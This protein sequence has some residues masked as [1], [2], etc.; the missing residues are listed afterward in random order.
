MSLNLKTGLLTFF[1]ALLKN[2]KSK[3]NEIQVQVL[4]RNEM[5]CM[6]PEKIPYRCVISINTPGEEHLDI[7]APVLYLDFYDTTDEKDIST[8]DAQ[9]IAAFIKMNVKQGNTHIIVHCDQGVSRSAGVA[10]AILKAYGVDEDIILK[11]SHYNI[12][13]RCYEYV[14]KAFAL[15]ITP[16]QIVEAQSKSRS[17]YLSEWPTFKN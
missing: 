11:S 13:P 2:K 4:S 1:Q 5:I 10:A 14:C 12:N 3:R 6:A 17:A 9:K 15:P 8:E 16:T 7:A